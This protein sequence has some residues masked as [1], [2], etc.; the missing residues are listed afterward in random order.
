MP[1]RYFAFRQNPM[2]LK[3]QNMKK[4]QHYIDVGGEVLPTSRSTAT[5]VATPI[6]SGKTAPS[7]IERTYN[8]RGKKQTR[9]Y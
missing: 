7:E 9:F 4:Y 5:A 8:I 2:F 3:D 6:Q 1:K